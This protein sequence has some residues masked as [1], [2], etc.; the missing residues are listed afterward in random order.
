MSVYKPKNS[1]YFQYDFQLRGIRYNGSTEC[2]TRREAVQVEA[3]IRE[4]ARQDVIFPTEKKPESIPLK[5][6]LG[7]FY[8]EVSAHTASPD[9]ELYRMGKITDAIGADTMLDEIG[10]DKIARM[11]SIRRGQNA[12]YR[13]KPV[14]NATVNRETELLRRVWKRARDLWDVKLGKEPKWSKHRLLEA[15][16]R[17]R[18]LS[19]E[20]EVRLFEALREDYR[21]MAR[22]A[23]LSGL[24]LKNVIR[25]TWAQVDFAAERI[26]VRMKSRKPGGKVHGIPMTPHMTALLLA[27]KGRHPIF[28]FTYECKR[29][30]SKG[31]VALRRKAD[32][33]PFSEDGWRKAW[34]DAL[35]TANVE[36]FRFHD[37][38]HTTATRI[39]RATG[40]IKLTQKLL[41]HSSI[42][43]TARYSHVTQDDVRDA[44]MQAQ[45]AKSRNNPE[46][47]NGSSSGDAGETKE[48]R[49]SQAS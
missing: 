11:V 40:N 17:V 1:P 41:G 49:R 28:V 6:A 20:E 39:T 18:S 19:D 42:V 27:E 33:Y 43:S 29:A 34:K 4:K 7:R 10:D 22:F 14:S 13:D 48:I 8:E 21:P 9:D 3:A 45:A 30:R 5:A 37:A 31:A 15:D 44:M 35:V 26:T 16:E 38:R 46:A 25:L 23:L 47:A 36:D 12:R 2:T 24:R 32:R